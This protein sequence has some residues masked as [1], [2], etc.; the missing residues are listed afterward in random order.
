[1]SSSHSLDTPDISTI[2]VSFNTRDLL[3]ECLETLDRETTGIAHETIVIDNASRDGSADMVAKEFPQVRLLCSETNLGFGPANNRGFKVALG[4][5]VVLLNSDAFPQP[6][7]IRRS[8][9]HMEAQPEVGIGGGRL[10]SR[11]GSWQ[12]SARMFPSLL[13]ELLTISGLAA[14]YPKSRLMGRADRT[15]A[16]PLEPAS[17]DWLPGAYVIIRRESLA[18]VGY[19]DER[20]FL[21]YEEVDLCRRIK[22]VGYRVWYWPD[23]VVVHIGGESSKT[24][25]RV[26]MSKAGS[27]L[28]LWRMRSQM[29]YYRKHHRGP[30]AWASAA[31]ESS[32]NRLRAIRASLAT[33]DSDKVGESRQI[34][35][36]I[37]QAWRETR[38]GMISP[39]QPW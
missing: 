17:V 11:D 20:F 39:P 30:G 28:T 5:Y 2:I 18:R 33:G 4:R 35:N 38:G 27:Q 26:A 37:K 23:I 12:P 6:G 31:L 9:E 15:W 19:F 3:R 29:L 21:Y 34:V 13:N 1:M 25:G 36:L 22:A 10:V 7:A 8:L 14:R 24:L 16:D 32:W